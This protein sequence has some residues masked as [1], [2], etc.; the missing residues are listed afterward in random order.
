V[1]RIQC[2]GCGSKLNAKRSLIGQTRKCPKCGAPIQIAEPTPPPSPENGAP[3][4]GAS[5]AEPAGEQALPVHHWPER[6]DRANVY[7]ICGRAKMAAQWQNN[8]EGWMLKTNA[9]YVSAPRNRDQLPSQGDFKLVELKL[10]SKESGRHL[11]GLMVYQLA[12]RWALSSLE[13][14]DD[15][16]AAKITGPGGLNKDQKNA[17]R[18][19]IKELFMHQIWEHADRVL[20][21]LGNTDYHSPGTP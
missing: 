13:R 16:I 9:G 2:P 19:A 17:V 12:A 4:E 20:E 15:A 7:L 5:H 1:I 18:N 11:V 10:E 14:G 3:S 8:G 6:L 21:Y